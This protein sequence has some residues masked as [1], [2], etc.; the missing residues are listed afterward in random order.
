[1]SDLLNHI[2][3]VTILHTFVETIIV[4]KNEFQDDLSDEDEED[5]EDDGFLQGVNL[6]SLVREFE[7]EA[8]NSGSQNLGILSL[9]DDNAFSQLHDEDPGVIHNSEDDLNDIDFN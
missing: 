4:N 8:S 6:T 7:M 1:M 2:I 3:P 5:D 9:A